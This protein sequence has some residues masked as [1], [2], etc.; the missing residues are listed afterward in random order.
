MITVDEAL[1]RV[2]Q[3]ARKAGPLEAEPIGLAQVRGR[4]LR[5]RIVADRDLPPFTRS[6]MDGFALRSS[7]TR[8]APV[9]LEVIEEIPAGRS[10]LK[11]VGPGQASRIMTGAMIPAGADAVQ[12]VEKTGPAGARVR[13]LEAVSA[14]E[15]V[16]RAGEDLRAGSVLLEPGTLLG[17]AG[18]ALLASCGRTTV[19]V[20]RRPRVAILPTGDELVPPDAQPGPS[21]IRESNGQALAALVDEAGAVGRQLPI[22]ADRLDALR[23]AVS[24]ALR[25]DDVVLVS[26]GVS[27]GAYDLVPEALQ[28]AGCQVMFSRVAIQP[29][30]PLVFGTAGAE[31]RTLVFGL[32][33]NPVSTM[34][35]FLVFA[36]PALRL[37]MGAAR[38]RNRHV[39]ARLGSPLTRRAGRQAW[40]PATLRHEEGGLVAD[41]VPSMGSADLVALSRADALVILPATSQE[42]PAGLSV[43]ALLLRDVAPS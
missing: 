6:A 36:R 3:A 20:A 30:K 1:E 8:G 13:I 22:V 25:E 14:G 31:G 23:E 10:P 43:Q 2:A 11:P 5:E 12:M 15:H 16:R 17:A 9:E 28:H 41:L 4:V 7:D 26:G 38:W 33:G 35:D 29:G 32:P 34:V 42:V 18:V 40:L 21:Q 24:T 19:S 39:T 37:L 27:M